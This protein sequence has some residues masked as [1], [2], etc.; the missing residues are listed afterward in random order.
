MQTRVTRSRSRSRTPFKKTVDNPKKS[1]SKTKALLTNKDPEL[2]PEKTIIFEQES[3]LP[4]P[5]NI[6]KKKSYLEIIKEY[7]DNYDSVYSTQETQEKTGNFTLIEDM[8]IIY[9]MAKDDQE[10]SHLSVFWKNLTNGVLKR[11]VESIRSRYKSYLK[12]LEKEDFDKILEHLKT[13]GVHGYMLKFG[14]LEDTRKRKL[15]EIAVDEKMKATSS[16]NQKEEKKA[17]AFFEEKKKDEVNDEILKPSKKESQWIV[18]ILK[19][20]DILKNNNIPLKNVWKIKGYEPIEEITEE[21]ELKS[22]RFVIKSDYVQRWVVDSEDDN[23]VRHLDISLERLRKQFGVDKSTLV[24]ALYSVSGDIAA[25]TE[26]LDNPSNDIIKWAPEDDQ[27]LDECR[28]ITDKSFSLLLR[29]KGVDRIKKRL[30]F[31][32]KSLPFNL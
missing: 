13:S 26:L 14:Q 17:H 10:S 27:V 7:I 9:E 20:Q 15:I 19:Y 28:T 8:K 31:L 32:K 30:D 23:Y 29:Y 24:E 5:K 22:H 6:L 12:Y 11:N 4:Q 2:S 3:N 18:H 1:P 25:L 16:T 21:E